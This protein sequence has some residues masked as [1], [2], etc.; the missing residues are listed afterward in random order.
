MAEYLLAIDAGTGSIRSVV[1]DTQGNQIAM[2]QEEWVHLEEKGVPNSMGFDFATNWELTKKVIKKSIQGIDAKKIIALS[3]TS[4]REGI[5]VYDKNGEPLW[6][7]ANVDARAQKEVKQLK[8]NYPDMEE[9]FYKTSGQTFALG[10][11][12][13]LLWLKKHKPKIYKK[14]AFVS[15]IGDFI[16]AKLSGTIAV[17][18]SNAGTTGIFNLSKRSWEKKMA[19]KVGIK[20]SIFP[21]VF[22]SGTIIGNVSKKAATQTGLSTH[23]KVVMGGGDV[24]LGSAGLG[25]VHVGDVAILG[26]SFWQ[27][28]VNIPK[29]TT[30]PK[31]MSIRINPHVIASQSQAEGITFFSGLILRWFLDAF[32]QD[33][34]KKAKKKGVSPYA[35]LEKKAKKVPVGSY[36][37]VP[38]FSD[39]M[40]YKKWYH[41]SPSLVNLSIDAT[42]TNRYSIYRSLLENNAI[43]SAINLEKIQKHTQVSFDS[44]VFAGGASKSD[45]LCQIVADA[46]GKK[47]K[48]PKVTD[49]T[50]LGAAMSAGVGA[51]VYE[52]IEDAAKKLIQW[53]KHFTPN[54]Q[55]HAS[56]KKLAKKW[57]KI[58]KKQLQL[59]DENLTQSM[60]QAPG[61]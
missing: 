45:L 3:A 19:K 50:A 40:N 26:G 27:Q 59:V 28:V 53:E 2:A 20:K 57:Q 42:K 48:V 35:L 51:G 46:T 8:K 7:V 4:M 17:D 23:T 56:Y 54:L 37:I 14:T 22:E 41:A 38:I 60:W 61:L 11:L 55:N 58:Y 21:P 13:R 5:V 24:Q 10:A 29:D 31:D 30:P 1:F 34:V 43:V 16:L 36:G 12:P 15:M 32:C 9:E 18:P 47:L 39:A 33:L 44:V 49:A 6:G 52:S 25:V